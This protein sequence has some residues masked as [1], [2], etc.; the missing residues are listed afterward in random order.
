MLRSLYPWGK[1]PS[2]HGTGDWVD[3]IAGLD[4]MEKRKFLTLKGLEIRP[5]GPPAHSQSLYRLSYPGAIL[6]IMILSKWGAAQS[7]E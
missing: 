6:H 7:V 4:D 5:L 2:I 1:S 3:P